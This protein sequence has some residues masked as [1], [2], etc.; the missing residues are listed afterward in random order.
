[1]PRIAGFSVDRPA[2]RQFVQESRQ[3]AAEVQAG[4]RHTK[5]SEEL[6]SV[7]DVLHIRG[8]FKQI[9]TLLT[10]SAVQSVVDEIASI[11][12]ES[13][14]RERTPA[15]FACR[16]RRVPG[17]EDLPES[18]QRIGPGPGECFARRA[19]STFRAEHDQSSS[20]ANT[21]LRLRCSSQLFHRLDHRIGHVLRHDVVL[22][23]RMLV[24]P[25]L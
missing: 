10:Q 6:A 17:S 16:T 15:R 22:H 9:R 12:V 19:T 7:R 3:M 21:R 23:P 5:S 25:V 18:H 24:C 4:T 11:L 20:S 14:E 8:D 13:N 1:M 2:L